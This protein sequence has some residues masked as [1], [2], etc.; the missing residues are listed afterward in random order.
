MALGRKLTKLPF[1]IINPIVSTG[2]PAQYPLKFYE[3]SFLGVP[4]Y[5][6]R[7]DW[8]QAGGTYNFSTDTGGQAKLGDR[9]AQWKNSYLSEGSAKVPRTDMNMGNYWGKKGYPRL[10]ERTYHKAGVE[11]TLKGL[12]FTGTEYFQIDGREV[13]Q[14]YGLDTNPEFGLFSTAGTNFMSGEYAG[15]GASF[16]IVMHADLY[17]EEELENLG[18]TGPCHPADVCVQNNSDTDGQ[19]ILLYSRQPVDPMFVNQSAG[20]PIAWDYPEGYT[21]PDRTQSYGLQLWFNGQNNDTDSETNRFMKLGPMGGRTSP[22]T[23]YKG[24]KNQP[25]CHN[26]P[27]PPW[28]STDGV[29]KGSTQKLG[30]CAEYTDY[31]NTATCPTRMQSDPWSFDDDSPDSAT[32]LEAGF[33][34]LLFEID[35]TTNWTMDCGACIPGVWGA[36]WYNGPLIGLYTLGNEKYRTNM[37]IP[38]GETEGIPGGGGN[39]LVIKRNCSYGPAFRNQTLFH[40]KLLFMGGTPPFNGGFGS[41]YKFAHGFKGT[42]YEV[43]MFEGKLSDQ[44]KLQLE[45]IFKK[46][47]S[48]A[49]RYY[50]VPQS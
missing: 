36:A 35:N 19:Q 44:D 18:T 12:H 42:L 9:V 25:Y 23:G 24:Q 43:L 4:W 16:L 28:D 48:E 50:E 31:P 49:G 37:N 5:H 41:G 11:Q 10:V 13:T 45:E 1:G 2:I 34:I 29:G 14:A 15:T 47:Y 20:A 46:K 3:Y 7:T 8:E 27:C 32:P 6:F 21:W 40:N 30:G 26:P 22:S 39:S 33:Q 17:E 38:L